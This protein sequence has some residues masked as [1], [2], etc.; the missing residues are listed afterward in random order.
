MNSSE[1]D[2]SQNVASK[3]VLRKNHTSFYLLKILFNGSVWKIWRIAL[4][5]VLCG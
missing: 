1:A 5:K 3:F 2:I 4:T